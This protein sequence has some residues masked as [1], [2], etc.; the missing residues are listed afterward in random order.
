MDSLQIY[1]GQTPAGVLQR[2]ATGISF[3]HADGYS[4]APVFLS[5]PI[6]RMTRHWQSL[7]PELASLLPQGLQRTQW[8]ASPEVANHAEWALLTACGADL[9]GMVSVLPDTPAATPVGRQ[10]DR[11]K[12]LHRAR[13]QPD[14]L[15]SLPYDAEAL[16]TFSARMGFPN[17][18]ASSE[19]TAGAIYSRKE[20]AFQL[21]SHNS[22][23][24][25]TLA[26]EGW[27][28]A[29]E[30]QL[31]TSQLAKDAGCAVATVGRTQTTDGVPVLW[32]E[33]FDRSG[34]SNCQRSRLESAQQ[35]LG[36]FSEDCGDES[37][38]SIARLVRQYCTNPKVQLM[39]LFQRV[40]FGWLT[41]NGN[42]HLS[43]WS[44]LQN[45]S[46]I[47]LSPAYGM[48]N[49]A[50]LSDQTPESAL[51]INGRRDGIERE[52]LL[53]Y[54]AREVCGLNTRII[55]RAM[56]QL[57]SVPWEQ[58]ILDSRL[59]KER[60]RAYFELLSERWRRLQ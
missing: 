16:A 54:F 38:E 18:L 45:G 10:S 41:G 22:S 28:E 8:Q 57:D 42:L 26:P 25:L 11:S 60:Q 27:P 56:K 13:I 51:S 29:V 6:Q 39:R 4:G 55:A 2:D 40:L 7:P 19:A 36:R 33:R 52:D 46:I 30:N 1:V 9:P 5:W 50:I 43:K 32:A 48:I 17:S 37:L 35:L 31:L 58:R 34:A 20:S 44:L 49:T 24:R 3:Q 12:P 23:Y 53:E 21:V 14:L 15:S 59:S 47:E